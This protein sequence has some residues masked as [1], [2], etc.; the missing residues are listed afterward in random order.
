MWSPA[1][2]LCVGSRAGGKGEPCCDPSPSELTWVWSELWQSR[3]LRQW[4]PCLGF[5]NWDVSEDTGLP[6]SSAERG[7]I[8]HSAASDSLRVHGLQLPRLLCPWN[9][10]GKNTGVGIHSLLQG[11][12]LT[13]GSNLGLLN[14]RQ[15]LYWLSNLGCFWGLWSSK[16]LCRAN[17]QMRCHLRKIWI[18]PNNSTHCH[19]PSPSQITPGHVSLG[20]VALSQLEWKVPEQLGREASVSHTSWPLI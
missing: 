2:Q 9:S 10:P 3:Q 5:R 14:C 17:R 4:T 7:S 20:L 15:I 6:S 12:F 8:S 13:W 11:I 19:Q 1:G 16:I 18:L